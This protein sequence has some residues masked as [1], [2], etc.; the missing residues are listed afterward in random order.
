MVF[1]I[2]VAPV[3]QTDSKGQPKPGTVDAIKFDIIKLPSSEAVPPLGDSKTDERTTQQ[4]LRA[5]FAQASAENN[6]RFM[7][8]G[9]EVITTSDARVLRVSVSGI[10]VKT[11]SKMLPQFSSVIGADVVADPM[12]AKKTG[13]L[14]M[15]EFD[16]A[17]FT[18]ESGVT[19]DTIQYLLKEDW[20]NQ[21]WG[22]AIKKAENPPRPEWKTEAR[23]KLADGTEVN[24]LVFVIRRGMTPEKDFFPFESEIATALEAYPFVSMT[25]FDDPRATKAGERHRQAV[26]LR[27]AQRAVP[28]SVENIA[29]VTGSKAPQWVL[30]STINRGFLDA[31]LARRSWSRPPPISAG[32][33]SKHL[34][35]MHVRLYGGTTLAEVRKK[36][37]QLMET[38]GVEYLRVAET[39][40]GV[41]IIAGADPQTVDIRDRSAQEMLDALEWEQIFVDSGI[42]IRVGAHVH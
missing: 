23:A 16:G 2:A 42:K 13:A 20:W 17:E 4:L 38:W 30:A 5:V 24:S 8:T 28:D 39:R 35:Q 7:P 41:N 1:A 40:D 29:P 32:S 6:E 25:G 21:R 34:W 22:D 26:S 33:S 11:A 37:H 9:H 15:G 19:E 27:W 3:E 14:Y 18:E 31:K 12:A 36:R 10:D